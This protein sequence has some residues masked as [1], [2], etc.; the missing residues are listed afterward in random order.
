MVTPAAELT[1]RIDGGQPVSPALIAA[2]GSLCDR[3]ED[4]DQDAVVTLHLTGA[5]RE[6]DVG[7][8]TVAL[9]SK[10]ERALRRLERLPAATVALT[11]GDCGGTAL[12]ALLATDYRVATRSARLVFPVQVGAAW[13]G[14]AL[15]RLAQQAGIAAVRRVV[16]FGVPLEA[17]DALAAGLVD[18]LAGDPARALA[19]ATELAGALSGAELAVR[20]QLLLSVPGTSFEDALGVHLAACDRTLR[21]T[22]A[23]VVP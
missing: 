23:E 14:M 16:L 22:R 11:D 3:A 6:L 8:L 15:Y 7:G 1:I 20:R 10:W 17:T 9:V 18:E 5:P 2:L 12:D 19:A 4:R 13:P 21:W